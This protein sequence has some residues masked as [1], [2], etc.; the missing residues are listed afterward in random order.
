MSK[1][2]LRNFTPCIDSIT[3]KY[4]LVTSAV[5]GAVWRYCQMGKGACYKGQN[6]IAKNL[7]MSRVTINKHLKIL[8]DEG[9]LEIVG[10]S[11]AGS[12]YYKDTGRAGIEI[13]VIGFDEGVKEIINPVNEIYY[14]VNEVYLKKQLRNNKETI[15][16][17]EEGG[18]SIPPP[19]KPNQEP[20][21]RKPRTAE[22][23]RAS[24]LKALEEGQAEHAMKSARGQF[25]VNHFPPE[26]QATI[27]IVC[28]KWK[29]SPPYDRKASDYKYWIASAKDLKVACGEFGL[30]LLDEVYEAWREKGF[31]V[32][33]PASLVKVTTAVAGRKRVMAEDLPPAVDP[34]ISYAW[35]SE[36]S[37]AENLRLMNET[38]KRVA[39]RKGRE[40]QDGE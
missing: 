35:N 20:E 2:E 24:T 32:S 36:L 40:G 4:G 25:G 31:F 33:S 37:E 9:Y 5:F 11:D 14:P 26:V 8:V 23:L 12:N 3:E 28:D 27:G 38:M 16:S 30:G 19:P 22:D 10:K 6:G 29:I 15:S 1:T 21:P 18:I 17:D 34:S 13:S 39:E 7:N